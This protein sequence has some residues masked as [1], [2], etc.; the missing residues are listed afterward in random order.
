MSGAASAQPATSSA[1]MHS[2]CPRLPSVMGYRTVGMAPMRR[3]A[4]VRGCGCGEHRAERLV[5]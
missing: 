3:S 4:Q 5:T 1:L 2:A